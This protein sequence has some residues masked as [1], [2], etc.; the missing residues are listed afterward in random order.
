MKL[1]NNIVTG[2]Y[3]GN[4]YAVFFN[5]TQIYSAGNSPYDTYNVIDPPWALSIETLRDY[6]INMTKEIAK[7]QKAEYGGVEKRQ[8]DR[9]SEITK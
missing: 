4:G 2:C 5:N 8:K 6:C 1:K 3:D 7:E 9:N